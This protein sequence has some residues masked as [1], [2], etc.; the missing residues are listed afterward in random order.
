MTSGKNSKIEQCAR[1][2]ENSDY[3]KEIGRQIAEVKT[4]IGA[5]SVSAIIM[6]A[7]PFHRAHERLVRITLEKS[8][9]VVIFLLESQEHKE[10][11]PFALRKKTL[12]YFVDNYL[13]KNRVLV[14][15]LN[16][17]AFGAD[18][19]NV[20]AHGIVAKCLGCDT[21][22]VGEYHNGIGFY[23]D[24]NRL[25]MSLEGCEK[26]ANIEVV[27]RF[28]FCNECNT[29]VSVKTCPHGMH[30]HIKYNSSSLIALLKEGILPPAMLMRKD[31][32][33]IILSAIY[34]SRFKNIAQIYNDLFPG[35]GLIEMHSD[36]D[37][38][39]ELMKLYQTTSLT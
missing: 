27:S 38:Y 1:N 4:N 26:S 7:N 8:D 21:L 31:I 14:I 24:N 23:Y 5:F 33:A 34:P 35:T 19:F 2:I 30:H 25:K 39:M 20:A 15:P 29:L 6:V 9:L 18:C 22:V 11:L 3:I 17:N 36:E 28:V 32:S 10:L 13:H 16:N 37:F 12:Q